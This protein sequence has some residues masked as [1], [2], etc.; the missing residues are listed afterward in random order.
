VALCLCGGTTAGAYFWL[1]AH[2]GTESL[3]GRKVVAQSNLRVAPKTNHRRVV[4]KPGS[5]QDVALA[6]KDWF[7][8]LARARSA[9]DR[10]ALRHIAEQIEAGGPPR[11][12]ELARA[13]FEEAAQ[14]GD[15][16]A[17]LR[18]GRYAQHGIGGKIDREAAAAW[19]E[20]A[21]ADGSAQ[22][23]TELA[24]LFI[25]G[26]AVP[27]D[28]AK[29]DEYLEKAMAAGSAEAMFLKGSTSLG[30]GGDPTPA[31]NY[32]VRAATLDNPDAQL[33]LSR[34]YAEGKYLPRDPALATEWALAAERNGSSDAKVDL[35][36]SAM[37]R[38]TAGTM[39]GVSRLLDASER[40]NV[41]AS[42]QLASLALSGDHISGQEIESTFASGQQA[43][44]SGTSFGA[45]IAATASLANSSE[46]ALQ[47]LKK[48]AQGN[49]W[50]SRHALQLMDAEGLDVKD[51]IKVAA[52]A[53]FAD[54]ATRS[55]QQNAASA[56]LTPPAAVSAPMPRF[57]AE[58]LGLSLNGY[59]NAEFTV[60]ESGLPVGIQIL[61]SSHPQ[62]ETA[63]RDAIARWA[64]KPAMQNG[65]P[66]PLKIRVPIQFRSSGS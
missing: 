28:L 48:G 40:S 62:L 18:A 47:W 27:V 58:L 22:G 45:F 61:S 39:E 64:F 44:E 29:A 10:A 15:T 4:P 9:H 34:L 53:S 63:A 2:S 1:Q 19:F 7:E 8:E 66:V 37:D 17:K 38:S 23:C 24:K 65:R 43:Y 21:A 11:D 52:Q 30:A 35:A 26:R 14:L 49:D 32:L 5:S 12:L 42:L 56:S 55:L 50:R 36:D 59:V 51:A 3:A 41:R 54:F 60:N 20:S 31:L 16:A 6:G 57:P 13:T 46:G 25:E 33:A